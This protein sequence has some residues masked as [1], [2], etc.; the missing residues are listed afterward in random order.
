MDYR[1]DAALDFLAT[2]GPEERALA[3]YLERKIER[4][5]IRLEG[6]RRAKSPDNARIAEVERMLATLERISAPFL[7]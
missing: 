7:S 3:L 2:L 6:L 4:V 1:N 5:T